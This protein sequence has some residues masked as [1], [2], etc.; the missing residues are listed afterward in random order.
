MF[1]FSSYPADTVFRHRF[2]FYVLIF[3]K[4]FAIFADNM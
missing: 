3:G 4:N 1:L 2:L